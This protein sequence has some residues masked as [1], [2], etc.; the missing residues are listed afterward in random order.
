MM[1]VRTICLIIFT[2]FPVFCFAG[3]D[4]PADME[5]LEY[6]GTFQTG[7]GKP[8]DPLLFRKDENEGKKK[9][10]RPEQSKKRK[11]SLQNG[12]TQEKGPEDEK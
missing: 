8:V 10:L 12:K 7:N 6:L 1:P 4:L 3:D 9:D 11:K 5:M 2:L